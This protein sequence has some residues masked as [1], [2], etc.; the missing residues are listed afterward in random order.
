M[1]SSFI[2][3][4]TVCLQSDYNH[5]YI[6][7]QYTHI[8]IILFFSW[9]ALNKSWCSGG[10]FPGHLESRT[11]HHG[12]LGIGPKVQHRSEI[13]LVSPSGSSDFGS[14][15]SHFGSKFG[16]CC[17][18]LPQSCQAKHVSPKHLRSG[19]WNAH[20]III[21]DILVSKGAH[22][23]GTLLFPVWW[24]SFLISR[25]WKGFYKLQGHVNS[26][27]MLWTC[28]LGSKKD[29]MREWTH[30]GVFHAIPSFLSAERASVALLNG[31]KLRFGQH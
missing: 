21:L 8:V 9:R 12:L 17:D 15:E 3:V 30:V 5:I 11:S 24:V 26:A 19:A 31:H 22:E 25:G 23:R 2:V 16:L 27:M 6:C 28:F 7:I 29:S 18:V 13:G 1:Y 20:C 14:Y 4:K 10:T